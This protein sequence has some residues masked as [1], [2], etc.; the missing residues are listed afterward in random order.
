MERR[1]PWKICRQCVILTRLA[2]FTETTWPAAQK[3]Q[4]SAVVVLL[5]S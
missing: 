3:G 5:A 2:V 1:K 4:S